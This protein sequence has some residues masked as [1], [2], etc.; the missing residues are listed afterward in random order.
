MTH[1]GN[2]SATSARADALLRARS[3]NRPRPLP[4][5]PLPPTNDV[6]SLPPAVRGETVAVTTGYPVPPRRKARPVAPRPS[7][8]Q[9]AYRDYLITGLILGAFGGAALTMLFVWFV[10]L[11]G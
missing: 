7:A 2:G 10:L 8:R 1:N 4:L 6:G 5:P 11:F 9:L 3:R